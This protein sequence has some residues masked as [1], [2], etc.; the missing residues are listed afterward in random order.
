MAL[1]KGSTLR[2]TLDFLARET[3]AGVREKVLARLEP[4]LRR[5]IE[6]AGPTDELPFDRAL[7]LWRAADAV[8]GR[9]DPEWPERAGEY[10]IGQTGAQLYAGILKKSN[11]IEFLTQPI[12]LFRLYYHP[13]DIEVVQA[14]EGSAILRLVEFDAPDR[15]FGRRQT[16]GLRK[17]LEL[18]GGRDAQVR[19]V[20][21]ELEGDA[22]CEWELSWRA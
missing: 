1:A 16:G 12:K 4:G 2:A 5:E 13:G 7:A 21:C 22:F 14:S 8:L 6:G 9:E 20:R 11:P 15:L 17:A 18:A 10:A 3:H 19:Q